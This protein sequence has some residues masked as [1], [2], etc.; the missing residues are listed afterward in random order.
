MLI[1]PRQIAAL[2]FLVLLIGSH[3]GAYR[4]GRN[5]MA[6]EW[7]QARA[8]QSQE[9]LEAVT[10]AREK[11]Q[12]LTRKA[13]DVQAKL[14]AEKKRA[15]VAA[16]SAANELRLLQEA[17]AARTTTIDPGTTT[18][19]DGTSA[20]ELLIQCA[21]VHQS[22]AA[23]ADSLANKVTGLQGYVTDVCQSSPSGK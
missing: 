20:S 23:E 10:V 5:T 19:A 11:E 3:F 16:E 1:T 9:L 15:S 4:L 18:G 22:V 7:A 13:N 8:Q 21:R 2:V 14:N 6:G 17:L 12:E